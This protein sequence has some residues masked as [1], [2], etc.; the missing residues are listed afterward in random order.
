VSEYL[1][2]RKREKAKGTKQVRQAYVM[3]MSLFAVM[4]ANEGGRKRRRGVTATAAAEAAAQK[5]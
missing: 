1:G 5:M 3:Y 4:K 2:E